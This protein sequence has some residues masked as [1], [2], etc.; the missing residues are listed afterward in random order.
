MLGG[1]GQFAQIGSQLG[2]MGAMLIPGIGP[3]VGPLLGGVVGGLFGGLFDS[4]GSKTVTPEHQTL[5][6]IE[7]AQRDTISAI[8][9][10]N[11]ALLNPDNRLLNLPSNFNVP[12]YIPQ[13]ASAGGGAGGG[14]VEYSPTENNFKV[15]VNVSGTDVSKADI[16]VAVERG[17]AK[18][19]REGRHNSPRSR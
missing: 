11:D 3:I 18:A 12:S 13:F 15:E 9:R 1:G 17:I 2:S 10:G 4:K 8:E 6:A 14:A 7:K 5:E 19:L 16:E